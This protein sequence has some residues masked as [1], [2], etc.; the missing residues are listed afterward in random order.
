MIVHFL[1][2]RSAV[3]HAVRLFVGWLIE[4][5]IPTSSDYAADYSKPETLNTVVSKMLK[6]KWIYG[7]AQ[8]LIWNNHTLHS[9]FSHA[10]LDHCNFGNVSYYVAAGRLIYSNKSN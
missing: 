5:C 2:D 9:R 10:V 6:P 7:S 4:N 8:S 1:T 3:V